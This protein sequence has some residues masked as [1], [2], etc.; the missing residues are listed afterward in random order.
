MENPSR[1]ASITAIRHQI[2]ASQYN[3]RRLR[4][5]RA[6]M[7]FRYLRWDFD[8]TLFNTYPPR[9]ALPLLQTLIQI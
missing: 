4:H 9:P 1:V 3:Q 6:R 5:A 7:R 2:G 8:G